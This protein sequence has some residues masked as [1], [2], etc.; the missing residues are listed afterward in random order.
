MVALSGKV[1]E[2][3]DQNLA[4]SGPLSGDP[5]LDGSLPPDCS[6]Q[7][8][9]L[10]WEAPSTDTVSTELQARPFFFMLFQDIPSQ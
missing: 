9:L 7:F 10:L 5:W 1:V 3:W 6:C 2:P 4:G 8:P